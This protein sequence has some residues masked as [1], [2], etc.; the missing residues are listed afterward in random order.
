MLWNIKPVLCDCST[1][2][3]IMLLQ[4]HT[5][6]HYT[7]NTFLTPCRVDSTTCE[8]KI[9]RSTL[10]LSLCFVPA[11]NIKLVSGLTINKLT[12]VFSTWVSRW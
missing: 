8:G 2:V 10:R 6:L 11:N 9:V 3:H 12:L 5:I 1:S 7:N 4:T